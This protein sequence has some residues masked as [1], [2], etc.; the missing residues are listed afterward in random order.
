MQLPVIT[1]PTANGAG[2]FIKAAFLLNSEAAMAPDTTPDHV[3]HR[4]I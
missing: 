3:E 2:Y 1:E 4:K